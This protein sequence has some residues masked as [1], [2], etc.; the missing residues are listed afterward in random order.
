[1]EDNKHNPKFKVK[2]KSDEW[3]TYG[4][5]NN[6]MKAF[7][8]ISDWQ[9]TEIPNLEEAN[10]MAAFLNKNE[11][12]YPAIAIERE[13]YEKAI[14]SLTPGGSEFVNEPEYCVKY[15]K[16]Y[17]QS[18]HDLIC[19][20]VIEKKS[21]VKERDCLN[22]NFRDAVEEVKKLEKE[23]ELLIEALQEYIDFRS[24]TTSGLSY[25]ELI[26]HN[27]AKELLNNLKK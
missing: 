13:R 27:K 10:K 18:Q 3:K 8:Y 17:Q 22:S 24:P 14:V 11:I 9:G 19:K 20:L 6:D 1:M 21:L 15:V 2:C 4:I 25:T 26:I 5:W 7:Q 23:R 12:S 16:E